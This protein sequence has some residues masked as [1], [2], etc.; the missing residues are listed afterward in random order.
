MHTLTSFDGTTFASI[1]WSAGFPDGTERGQWSVDSRVTPRTGNTSILAP[2][3]ISPRRIVVDFS[4]LPGFDVRTAA[5]DLLGLLDPRPQEARLLVGTREPS[6]DVVQ[7]SARVELPDGFDLDGS[8][9]VVRAVFVSEEPEWTKT[10]ATT[11]SQSGSVSPFQLAETNEGKATVFP[12]YR[13]GWSVQRG[14]KGPVVGQALLRSMTL[15]NTQSRTVPPFPRRINLG[16]T[17]ALVSGGK[18]QADGDDLRVLI[19]GKDR[20]RKLI[21]WNKTQTYA[22]VTIPGMD[23]GEALTIDVVYGNASATDP[24]EWDSIRDLTRPVPDLGNETGTATGGSPTTMVRASATWDADRWYGGMLTMLTGTALNVGVSREII[25][26]SGTT[27]TVSPAFPAAVVNTDTYLITMSGNDRW[28]YQTL[29]AERTDYDRGRFNVNSAQF[30]PSEIS[31]EGPGSW[32]P[33]LVWD[34][35]DSFGIK[36]VSMLTMGGSDKDPFALLEAARMWEGNDARVSQ[37]GTADGMSLT[38]HVPITGCDW[39]YL[40]DNPNGMVQ[41]WCGVR[42]SGAEDWAEVYV[43]EAATSGAISNAMTERTIQTDFGDVYQIVHALGPVDDL[44]I[45]LDWRRDTGSATSGTTTVMTDSSKEWAV[46]QF[47][48]GTIRMLSGVNAGKKRAITSNTSTAITHAAFPVANADGDRYVVTNKRLKGTLRDDDALLVLLDDS[49]LTDSGLGAETAV[50][51]ASMTLWVGDG[52]AGDA[53]GQHRALIGYATNGT[54]AAGEER[55]IFLAADEQIEIDAGLRRVRIWNTTS[56][57]YTRELTDP[58]V[59]VQWHNGT[60]WQ[61]SAAWLPLGTG[62]QLLWL[63]E[64]NIGTLSLEVEYFASYLGA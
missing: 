42:A 45:A 37:A 47:D 4:L 21:G 64:T 62:D 29:V 40:M 23:A 7:R 54:A 14:T 60:A 36:R 13:I 41:A 19:D 33:A 27:I 55:R 53:D 3:A 1:G 24:P 32:V 5:G 20:T 48:N 56:S 43:D 11:A 30:T 9:N 52:P 46:D 2:G 57:T 28:I 50:Y 8:L 58:A 10:A 38:T 15:T 39:F 6:G 25:S 61:R 44:E 49:K 18:A 35:R 16:D 26:N 12:R 34:N 59:I 51:E 22:W 63:E 31:Y 17:A